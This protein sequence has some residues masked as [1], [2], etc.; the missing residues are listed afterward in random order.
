MRVFYISGVWGTACVLRST[1]LF[2]VFWPIL[3]SCS[4]DWF[5]LSIYLQVFQ[6]LYQSFGDFPSAPSPIGITITFMF[7]SFL[8]F[9]QN[10]GIYLSFRF[11]LFLLCWDGKFTIKQFLFINL[12]I[13]VITKFARLAEIR[14]SVWISKS[15][16]NLYVLFTRTN[17]WFYTFHFFVWSNFSLSIYLFLENNSFTLIYP[18]LDINHQISLYK[19]CLLTILINIYI[20][21]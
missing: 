18:I 7:H 12:F 8:V 20:R 19:I 11:L 9:S 4:L 17:Y 15:Q 2:S 6:S 21:C 5:F 3:I 1:G 10:L 16:K 13:F 14:W